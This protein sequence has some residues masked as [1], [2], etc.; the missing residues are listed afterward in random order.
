MGF[1]KMFVFCCKFCVRSDTCVSIIVK[2]KCVNSGNIND[3]CDKLKFITNY[4]HFTTIDTYFIKTH[5]KITIFDTFGET[6]QPQDLSISDLKYAKI[7]N[8]VQINKP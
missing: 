5:T 3:I 4:I 6:V 8:N 1:D 7:N 2:I